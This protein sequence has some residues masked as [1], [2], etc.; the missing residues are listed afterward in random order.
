MPLPCTVVSHCLRLT[1]TRKPC[2]CGSIKGGW[3]MELPTSGNHDDE[4]T[5]EQGQLCYNYQ[6]V[7]SK[8]DKPRWKQGGL[9]QPA[10]K[11]AQCIPR[12]DKLLL[13]WD[14]NARIGRDNDKW[15]MVRGKHGIGKCNSNGE[16]LLALCSEFERTDSDE[17]HIQAD[18]SSFQTLPY[19]RLHHAGSGWRIST[20]PELFRELTAG[21]ISRCRGQ[22][23]LSEY[24]K[25]TTG[26]GR[27][28]QRS[29]TQQN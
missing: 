17:H 14:F 24:D 6:C 29:S 4:T 8:N 19:D 20:V 1:L 27:V 9:L 22:K 15:P 7:R 16:L 23:W 12:T 5:S 25:S 13:I 18:A 21:S 2:H 11:C 3:C 28:S 10:G 26:K